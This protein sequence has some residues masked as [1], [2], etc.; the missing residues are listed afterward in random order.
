[1]KTILFLA[2]SFLFSAYGSDYTPMVEDDGKKKA[3]VVIF[4]GEVI[5]VTVETSLRFEDGINTD[6]SIDLKSNELIMNFNNRKLSGK[7]KILEGTSLRTG[8]CN[9]TIPTGGIIMVK[10]GIGRVALKA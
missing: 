1:M 4:G 2:F 8:S 10:N 9:S 5:C 6:G 7:I 3:C